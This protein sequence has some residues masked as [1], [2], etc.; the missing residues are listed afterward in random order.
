MNR[1]LTGVGGMNKTRRYRQVFCMRDGLWRVMV[2]RWTPMLV[3]K[4]GLAICASQ[5]RT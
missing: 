4:G 2:V 1:L 5:S 3:P